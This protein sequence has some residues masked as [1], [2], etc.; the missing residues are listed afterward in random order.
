MRHVTESRNAEVQGDLD[1]PGALLVT[2]G[3]GGIVYGL[4]ESSNAGWTNWGIIASILSGILALSGF[5]AVEM[6]RAAPMMPTRLF[7]SG[8][9]TGGNLLTLLLYAALGGSL[10]FVPLNLIQ[11][12]GYSTTAAGAALLPLILLL[13]MLSRWSG[14]LVERYGAKVPLVIGPAWQRVGLPFWPFPGSAAATGLRSS[15]QSW[16]WGW[17]WRSA[18]RR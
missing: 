12:Q 2:L 6:H 16:S 9:F 1:W 10:F 11:V 4:I 5:V 15:L 8:A 14:G 18:S 13:S 7:R 17:E 3:L